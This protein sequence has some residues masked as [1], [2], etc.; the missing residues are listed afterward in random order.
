MIALEPTRAGF[1]LLRR[2]ATAHPRVEAYRLGLFNTTT[3]LDLLI[4]EG[5]QRQSAIFVEPG[6]FLQSLRADRIDLLRLDNSGLEVAALLALGDRVRDMKAIIVRYHRDTDRRIVDDILVSTHVLYW[7]RS[8]R[9]HQGE[10]LYV[11]R[12]LLGPDGRT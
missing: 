7:G 2:N 5:G 8:A 6:L 1:V 10:F 4:G 9:P 12:A 3:P 11:Q